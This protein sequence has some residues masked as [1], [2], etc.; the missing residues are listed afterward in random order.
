MAN[1]VK[2]WIVHT[3]TSLQL[4]S[5]STH[6]LEQATAESVPPSGFAMP[7]RAR[8]RQFKLGFLDV[9]H[10]TSDRPPGRAS[11]LEWRRSLMIP[12]VLGLS[13]AHAAADGERGRALPSA[14]A[15]S[16]RHHGACV[17][18]ALRLTCIS[19]LRRLCLCASLPFSSPW[20][21]SLPLPYAAAAEE[22]AMQRWRLTGKTHIERVQNTE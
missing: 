17:P 12:T 7:R 19:V 13:V 9:P 20:P 14:A 16:P 6:T 5:T 22:R 10:G 18:L 4:L 11:N 8:M 1:Q 15:Q 2:Y 3:R 21:L